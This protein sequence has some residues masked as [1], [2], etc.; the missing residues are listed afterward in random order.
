MNRLAAVWRRLWT[1]KSVGRSFASFRLRRFD[2]NLVTRRFDGIAADVDA[3]LGVVDVLPFE[4]AAL[5]APHPCG[6]DEFEVRFVQDAHGFQRLNQLFHRF[7][8]RNFL[9]LLLPSVFVGARPLK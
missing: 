9:F 2:D 5:A 3:A 4:R 6:D 8:V 7:I 1:F